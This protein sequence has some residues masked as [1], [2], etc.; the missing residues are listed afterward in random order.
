MPFL[1]AVGFFHPSL[2]VLW[3]FWSTLLGRYVLGFE[4]SSKPQRHWSQTALTCS[5]PAGGKPL[6][7]G[8]L[9][10]VVVP[11]IDSA[12]PC[13]AGQEGHLPIYPVFTLWEHE[14]PPWNRKNCL[15]SFPAAAGVVHGK[16]KWDYSREAVGYLLAFLQ[17]PYLYGLLRQN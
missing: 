16:A 11:P 15:S 5:I 17:G 1:R 4:H 8:K 9:G 3:F 7:V 10:C 14:K 2:P 12:A 6:K 13:Y